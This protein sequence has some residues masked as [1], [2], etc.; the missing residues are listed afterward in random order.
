MAVLVNGSCSPLQSKIQDW[1]QYWLAPPAGERSQ[2]HL[3]Q[4]DGWVGSAIPSKVEA[5][6]SVA[7]L[8]VLRFDFSAQPQDVNIKI[9][10]QDSRRTDKGSM[11]RSRKAT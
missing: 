10:L 1:F 5:E 3:D 8:G 4:Y 7:L 6:G 9:A 2:Q 11:K